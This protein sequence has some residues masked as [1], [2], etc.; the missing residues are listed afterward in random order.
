M[1]TVTSA[2]PD[3]VLEMVETVRQGEEILEKL[4]DF[5]QHT[6]QLLSHALGQKEP[7]GERYLY[8]P[9]WG[10]RRSRQ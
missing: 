4:K 8:G 9:G 1:N 5:S 10:P 3:P 6:E 7:I 2:N